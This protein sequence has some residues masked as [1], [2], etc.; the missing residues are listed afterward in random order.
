MPLSIGLVGL[1]NAGK[2]TV[3]NVLVQQTLAETAR[4]PFSTVQPHRALIEV[5]D[6]RLAVLGDLTGQQ[7]RVPAR[8]E[9]IDI[10]GLVQGASR[11]EGLGNQF[12]HQIRECD[13]LLHVLDC[14]SEAT[15]SDASHDP[16]ARLAIV[17][18]ELI[19]SDAERL[20]NRMVRLQRAVKGDASLADTLELV[21]QARDDLE[22]GIMLRDSVAVSHPAF[23]ALNAEMGF[24]TAKPELV[25]VN[26]NEERIK[27]WTVDVT[28]NE[29]LVGNGYRVVYMC[30]LM[31]EELLDMSPA[32]EAAFRQAY[33]LPI[34]G[35]TNVIEGCFSLLSL[36]RFYTLGDQEV[37]AWTLSQGSPAVEGAAKIHTDF[38]H[39][40]IAAD[41]VP[42]TV[43]T[44]IGSERQV[45]SE[46]L[47]RSEGRDYQ[48]QDGDIV[49]FK[50]NL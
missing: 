22:R 3:F 11:G 33:G 14:Y 18:Q 24:I 46:G 16:I 2:S 10:A 7:R 42:F 44:A 39:G 8:I 27:D 45:R 36:I 32:D 41:V 25:L 21:V 1:P 49:R 6:P 37:R 20:E 30:A 38:A 35:L 50:F 12:L 48:I 43:F 26:L 34:A 19:L 29:R 47:M 40:F 5:P 15:D 4:Y 9:I 31:E 23:P 13:A 17:H 28:T